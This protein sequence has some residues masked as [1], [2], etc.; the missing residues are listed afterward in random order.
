MDA[1]VGSKTLVL[2]VA[3]L[4]A[5]ALAGRSTAR[6]VELDLPLLP[7]L[8]A[9]EL[10]SIAGVPLPPDGV[11]LQL[12]ADF[13][14]EAPLDVAGTAFTSLTAD[15][16]S[17]GGV[18]MLSAT[19]AAA[20]SAPGTHVE[21]CTDPTFVPTGPRWYAGDLPVEWRFRRGSVPD[22][23]GRFRSQYSLQAAHQV[24]ARAKT[25]C[26]SSADV[27]LRFAFAG[28]SV[29]KAGYDGVNLVDFGHLGAGALAMSYTW[30]QGGHILEADLRLNRHDY[31]W[32][33]RPGGKNRYQ[34]ANVGAHEIGHQVGLDDL[35]DPHGAL[36]MFGRISLGETSKTTLG[37]GDLR[38]AA[39]LSP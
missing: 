28:S 29:R 24:W 22:G 16:A 14:A 6:S 11:T 13:P 25:V 5:V 27:S 7:D 12:H 20:G 17:D 36:T 21:E 23:L 2:V 15:V 19:P 33:N 8:P 37:R 18:T 26:K 3:A 10:L 34:V 4:L 1:S 35:S 38:G 30:Y 39:A 31:R 9:E 32:T